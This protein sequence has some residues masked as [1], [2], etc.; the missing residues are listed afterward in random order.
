[1]SFFEHF[2]R[3]TYDDKEV[4]NILTRTKLNK[5][6]IVDTTGLIDF[7][8]NDGDRQDIISYLAYK[9]PQQAW[10]V[11]YANDVIDPYHDWYLST[12]DFNSYIEKKY[13]SQATALN[14]IT[15]YSVTSISGDD[16]NVDH[17][18]V[19]VNKETFEEE[20]DLSTY[21]YTEI[22]AFDTE[23]EDNTARLKIKLLNEQYLMQARDELVKKLNE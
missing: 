17:Y 12:D 22:N 8:L 5:Q 7:T 23:L 4:V 14:E 10:L 20:A 18:N 3:V 16:R 1:M 9:D 11:N 6:A 19:V 13:G 15:G 21:V 2:P